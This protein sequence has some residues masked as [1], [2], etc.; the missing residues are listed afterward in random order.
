MEEG[1]GPLADLALNKR[2]GDALMEARRLLGHKQISF[3]PL[4]GRAL[5]IEVTENRLSKWERGERTVP[6]AVLMAAAKLANTPIEDL[7]VTP[8]E[9]HA[10]RE[11]LRA[12]RREI[13]E[14]RREGPGD[15]V[16]RPVK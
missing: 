13:D 9:F 4:L 8:E 6:A 10:F 2:A 16:V 5:G 15:Q 1:N 3:A 7:T 14:L 12:L 11:E